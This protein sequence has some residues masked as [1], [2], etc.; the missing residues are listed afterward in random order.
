MALI[1]CKECGRQI[2]D[3]AKVCQGCGAPVTRSRALHN[4]NIP[5]TKISRNLIGKTSLTRKSVAIQTNIDYNIQQA[6]LIIKKDLKLNTIKNIKCHSNSIT[7]EDGGLY[8][9][10]INDNGTLYLNHKI[11]TYFLVLGILVTLFTIIGVIAFI[12]VH[13]SVNSVSKRLSE[14]L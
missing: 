2:S 1:R 12:A 3:L 13:L 9:I 6:Y 10:I 7:F 14:I 8:Y 11:K 4:S 5:I